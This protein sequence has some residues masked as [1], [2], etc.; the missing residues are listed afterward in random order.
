MDKETEFHYTYS[1]AANKEVQ[2]I[3]KKYLPKEESKLDELKRLDRKVQT[4]GIIES[5][6]VG[7]SGFLLFGLGIC[8]T[9]GVVGSNWLVG[10]L[11]G[12][13]SICI[14]LCA[15]PVYRSIFGKSKEKFVPRI[16]E[17]TADFADGK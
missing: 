2:E 9:I 3:R 11:L 7:I 5:L 13:V 12:F 16:L 15:Y 1:A 14:M 8:M 17:L 10:C 4:A 6:T